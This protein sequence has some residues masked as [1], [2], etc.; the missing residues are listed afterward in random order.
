MLLTYV[1]LTFS[2]GFQWNISEIFKIAEKKLFSTKLL[3]SLVFI[4]LSVHCVLYF[5]GIGASI[6]RFH[7]VS[8]CVCFVC[9]FVCL[10]SFS[11]CFFG[12]ILTYA[13]K[14]VRN[15]KNNEKV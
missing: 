7:R 2:R 4:Y 12:L 1:I 9:L 6:F 10:F 8:V 15:V 3:Y 11:K 5:V 14:H 13:I